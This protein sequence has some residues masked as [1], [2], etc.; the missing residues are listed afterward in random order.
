MW[1]NQ[2]SHDL[3]DA[4]PLCGS[5]LKS[6]QHFGDKKVRMCVRSIML[7]PRRTYADSARIY[8][9]GARTYAF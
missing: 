6:I 4:L 8:A 9:D 1:A 2:R 5:H 7:V 3:A